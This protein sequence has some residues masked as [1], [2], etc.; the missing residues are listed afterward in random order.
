[1]L[2]NYDRIAGNYDILSRLIFGKAIV[3]AQ[4]SLIPL[5]HS[6]ARMLIAGGGTGWILEEI[7][8]TQPSGLSIDY[9]EISAKMI[10]L[11][12]RRN[13]GGNQV[14][15]V[16]SGIEEF[17]A[18]A[19]Y[20]FVVTPF[21]F[22]NFNAGR[23]AVVF[24]KL[25]AFL[26]PGSHWLFTDFHIGNGMNAYWQKALLRAMYLFFKTIS[27][28]EASRLPDMQTLFNTFG[29]QLSTESYRF[30]GFIRSAAYQ[31]LSDSSPPSSKDKTLVEDNN[32]QEDQ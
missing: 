27:D 21:L 31:K 9:V 25:H 4:Q 13:F 17:N 24:Q 29:Y 11:A 15:F 22:D 18:A 30:G 32:R 26:I 12:R 28:V 5:I 8:L 23:A 3:R 10:G 20:D 16:H 7:A 14:T 1:M 6:P 2:N 19:P